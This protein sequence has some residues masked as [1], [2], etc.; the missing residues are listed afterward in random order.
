MGYDAAFRTQVVREYEQ[1]ATIAAL[2]RRHGVSEPTITKWLR[3]AGVT[4]RRANGGELNLDRELVNRLYDEGNS[5]Y[6][7]ARQLGCSDESVRL[8]LREV[9]PPAER[10]RPDDHTKQ[11]LRQASADLWQDPGYRAR[12]A[13]GM[14]TPQYRQALS[15]AARRHRTLSR[16]SSSAAGRHHISARAQQHWQ[17]PAYR[18]KQAAWAGQRTHQLITATRALLADPVRRANWI[19]RLRT[20]A[21]ARRTDTGWISSSQRQF[22]YLL[23]TAGVQYRE[24]GEGTKVGPFYV[25]DCIIHRQQGMTKDLI[26]EIQGEY[27]HSLPHV[28]L[29]DRQ[30]RTWTERYTDYDLLCLDE[31]NLKSF[32]DVRT[33]LAEYGLH[34]RGVECGLG[35]LEVRETT[36]ADAQQFYSVFHYSSTIRRGAVTYGAYLRQELVAAISYTA[37]MR[38]QTAG[39]LGYARG[40]VLEISRLAR[41][42]DLVCPN[43]ASFLIARSRDRLD[44]S[45]KCVVS[46]SDSTQGHAGTVYRAAGFTATGETQ[47]D[48]YWAS[49]LGRHHKKTIWDR[50]KRMKL[51]EQDYARRHGLVRVETEPK[52]RWVYHRNGR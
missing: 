31:L 36:E 50:A 46:F 40:E 29:K 52:T 16:W 37:P 10:N 17:D 43:L 2:H 34:L 27:W 14:S 8:L 18:R 48:Y 3:A 33:K 15:E 44:S 30:K 45:V 32:R 47:P 41:R 25:V 13:A 7:I 19:D 39:S 9:R 4:V 28:A 11:K 23:D 12:V 22:Y 51:S 38:L 24:E 21:A 35:D 1:G 26:V 20:A 42:T 49:L 5:T 6:D